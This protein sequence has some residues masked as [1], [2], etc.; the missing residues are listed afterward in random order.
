MG[1]SINKYKLICSFI[2]FIVSMVS[3]LS[4]YN[5]SGVGWDFVSHY[6]NG[7]TIASGVGHSINMSS[8]LNVGK[9]FYFDNVWEPLS[10]AIIA[11]M[12]FA[13]K[14]FALPVYLILL[15]ALLFITSYITAKKLDVDPLLLS[16]VIV[17]PYMISYTVLYN[18]NEIL[19]SSFALLAIGFV[20]FKEY[21]SGIFAGLVGLSK[22][23]GL[24]ILPILLLLGKRKDIYKAVGLCILVTIPWLAINFVVF[25]N[26]FQS[27]ILQLAESQPQS[28]SIGMF[29][30]TL[31][32]ILWYPATILI[33]GLVW[34]VYAEATR[35][36]KEGMK[37][38][39]LVKKILKRHDILVLLASSVL[40]FAGFGFSYW[41]AQGAIRLGFLL[42]LSLAALAVVVISRSS[43]SKIVVLRN[44]QISE[45][46]PYLVF[47]ISLI[48]ALNIYVSWAHMSFNVL[49][50]LGFKNNEFVSAAAALKLHNLTECSIVSNAWPYMNYYNVTTY[51]P[52]YCN[53]TVEKMPILIFNNT[54]VSNY[55]M[56][57]VNNITNISEAFRYSNF[58][59]YLPDSYVCIK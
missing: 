47:G 53:S 38:I 56:G 33:I 40:A 11:V 7:R 32:S 17:G 2:L 57:T 4:A 9:N 13:V 49:G 20:T 50:S 22:Y 43:I 8:A 26:P 58:S 51:S 35:K 16:S 48:L 5:A 42:Y 41:N 12:I 6:L 10:P 29:M 28:G 14:S 54:G 31:F 52:Y 27:Y 25:G 46:L 37:L 30:S 23:T 3:I 19:A 1:Y 24:T 39:D 45:I 21:K 59:V 15:L 55:C 34:M 36:D 18:G 44:Y